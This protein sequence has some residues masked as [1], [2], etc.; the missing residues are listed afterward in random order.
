MAYEYTIGS[1]VRVRQRG[2]SLMSAKGPIILNNCFSKVGYTV[3]TEAYALKNRFVLVRRQD[4]RGCP[5]DN[6]KEKIHGKQFILLVNRCMCPD[7]SNLV[8]TGIL[9]YR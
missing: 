4:R 9:K 8:Y 7:Q 6:N 1:P 2:M 3:G 5:S